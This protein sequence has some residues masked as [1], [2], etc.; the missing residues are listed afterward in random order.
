MASRANQVIQKILVELKADMRQVKSQ[1][2]DL[3]PILRD[4][5]AASLLSTVDGDE[6]DGKL[7]L[8]MKEYT[9]VEALE[10]QLFHDRSVKRQLVIAITY[11]A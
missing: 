3:K 10:E 5:R 8:P 4:V 7:V 6:N 11:F 9:E 2:N 1:I